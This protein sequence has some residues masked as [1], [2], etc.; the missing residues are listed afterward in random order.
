MGRICTLACRSC[1]LR[2]R[3]PPLHSLGDV[4][5]DRTHRPD[6][7][8]LRLGDSTARDRLFV[9]LSLSVDRWASV[10]QMQA[11][12]SRYLAFSLAWVSHHDRRGSDQIARRPVLARSNLSLLSLRDTAD[13]ESR[14]SLP[15]LCAPLVSQIRNGMELFRR[16]RRAVVFIWPATRAACRRRLAH[17]VSNL[18][19]H[20]RQPLFPQL[21]DNHSVSG[22]L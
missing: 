5:V 8:R 17:R 22:V 20:Q 13:P 15:S 21:P 6:L 4:H 3:D 16:T 18:S 12:D 10:P 14:Q 7:V 11:A 2:K 19:H 9:D 1:W